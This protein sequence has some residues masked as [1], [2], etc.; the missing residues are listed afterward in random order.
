MCSSTE[1]NCV[2]NAV[3]MILRVWAM[4]GGSRIVLGALLTLY[5]TEVVVWLAY[6]IVE[7]TRIGS[8]GMQNMIS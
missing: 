4:Y 6:C 2:D 1:T 8:L 5:A 7:S 3:V